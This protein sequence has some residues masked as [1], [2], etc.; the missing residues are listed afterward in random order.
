MPTVDPAVPV[1]YLTT[2]RLGEKGQITVPKEYRDACELEAGTP[3]TML[4]L[5]GSLLLIPEQSRFRQL[6][7]RVAETF[8]AHRIQADEILHTL[9]GA[10]QRVFARHYPQLSAQK[11][12]PQKKTQA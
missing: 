3:I 6:S 2:A 9:P 4:R 10:R 5:G 12:T 8:A 7:D 1:A 11:S